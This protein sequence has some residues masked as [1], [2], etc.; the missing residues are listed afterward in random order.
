MFPGLHPDF[1]SQ[2]KSEQRPGNEAKPNTHPGPLVH[3]LKRGYIG[4]H[5]PTSRLGS[6]AKIGDGDGLGS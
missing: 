5:V 3:S 2:I 4:S 6:L 1:I